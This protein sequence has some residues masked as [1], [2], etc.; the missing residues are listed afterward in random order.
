MRLSFY[1]FVLLCGIASPGFKTA[2]AGDLI[3]FHTTNIQALRGNHYEVGPKKRTIITL[4]HASGW[5]I[6][7]FYTFC[8]FS[9][10]RGDSDDDLYCEFTPRLSWNKITGRD[11]S[12]GILKDVLLTAQTEQ[13]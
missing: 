7:D 1:F 5:N 6:G 12:Y 4:E 3:Q 9:L 10:K 2:K 11:V 8:D 13:G